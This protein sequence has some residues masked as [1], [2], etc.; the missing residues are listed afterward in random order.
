[1][2]L[3]VDSL[4]HRYPNGTTALADVSLTVRAAN[5]WRSWVPTERARARWPGT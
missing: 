5:V 1:M 3:R 2:V 4:S